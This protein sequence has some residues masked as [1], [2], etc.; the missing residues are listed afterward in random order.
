MG[1]YLFAFISSTMENDFAGDTLRRLLLEARKNAGL[2]QREVAQRLRRPQSY[3][4][5][6]ENGERILSLVDFLGLAEALN[7]HPAAVFSDLLTEIH[8]DNNR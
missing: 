1:F 6:I 8:Y 3:V 4:S 2:T 5:K 7:V